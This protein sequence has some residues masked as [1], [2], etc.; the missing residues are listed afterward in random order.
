MPAPWRRKCVK[1]SITSSSCAYPEQCVGE[2]AEPRC[3]V[4]GPGRA[5]PNGTCGPGY[6]VPT[7]QPTPPVPMNGSTHC[8][9]GNAES[10]AGDAESSVTFSSGSHVTSSSSTGATSDGSGTEEH[11]ARRSHMKCRMHSLYMGTKAEPRA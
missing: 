1:P 3:E 2:N 6:V 11:A 10:V 8:T 9:S 5:I 7:P 4:S